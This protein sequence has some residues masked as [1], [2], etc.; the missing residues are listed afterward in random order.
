MDFAPSILSLMHTRD[1]GLTF[2]GIDFTDQIYNRKRRIET[3]HI[4]Y[5]FD[6]GNTPVWAAAIKKQIK[7]VVSGPD[8]PWLFDLEADPYEVHNYFDDPKYLWDRNKLLDELFE[9]MNNHSIPLSNNAKF[10]HWSTPDCIDTKDRINITKTNAI[11]CAELDKSS[12]KCQKDRF[13]R[14]CPWTCGV[15]CKNSNGEKPH[16]LKKMWVRGELKRCK[17]LKSD[18]NKNKVQQFCPVTCRRQTGCFNAQGQEED[19]IEEND[20]T[21]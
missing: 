6:T 15:C 13:Q 20:Y 9:T 16:N 10:I 2:D 17:D 21:P 19:G 3:N 18:C 4:S 11:T 8:I 12:P 1:H 14:L 7:L 5:S